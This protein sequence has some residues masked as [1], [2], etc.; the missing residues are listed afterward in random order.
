MVTGDAL[1]QAVGDPSVAAQLQ[2]LLPE[3]GEDPV[4][5]VSSPQ[6]QQVNR[7][8]DFFQLTAPV[9]MYICFPFV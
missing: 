6:F 3:T 5:I 7:I 8:I 1:R 4:T 9:Q 2:S